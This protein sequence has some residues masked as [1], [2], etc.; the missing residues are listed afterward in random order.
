[1]ARFRVRPDWARNIRD[2]I[3]NRSFTSIILSYNEASKFVVT[4]GAEND[5]PIKVVNLGAGVKKLIAADSVCPRC[6][7]KG[8]LGK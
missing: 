4:C 6:G 3:V 8:Y 5:F 2:E 1:M 7:G